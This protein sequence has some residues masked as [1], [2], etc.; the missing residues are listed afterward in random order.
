MRIIIFLMLILSSCAQEGISK[1]GTNNSNF[2]VA[3]LFEIDGIKVYRFY[4]E[5]RYHWFTSK[6]ECISTVSKTRICGKNVI[7][8]TYDENI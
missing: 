8:R 3:Y 1:R 2:D 7:V 5:G 4:D 6:S